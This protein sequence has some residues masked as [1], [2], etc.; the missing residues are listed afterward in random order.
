MKFGRSDKKCWAQLET[1]CI[2]C[3]GIEVLQVAETPRIAERN[4][5]WANRPLLVDPEG[6]AHANSR[7]MK[8]PHGGWNGLHWPRNLCCCIPVYY[9]E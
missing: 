6:H 9:Y 7:A 1:L 4:G 5:K 3:P 8:R 2:V